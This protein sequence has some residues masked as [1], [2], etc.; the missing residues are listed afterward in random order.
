MLEAASGNG[1]GTVSVEVT[2]DG[3][4]DGAE[5]V[6]LYIHKEFASVTRPVKEL[7]AFKRIFLKNGE[8]TTVR[9]EVTADMLRCFGADGK[10]SVEPGDY[11]LMTGNS[12]QDSDLKTITLNVR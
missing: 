9:F 7:K 8:S 12:S 10:W 4:L 6:Q 5:V 1:Y 3:P 11:T 2:N